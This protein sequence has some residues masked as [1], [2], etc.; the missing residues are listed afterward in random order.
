MTRSFAALLIAALT[1]AGCGSDAAEVGCAPLPE[2]AAASAEGEPDALLWTG[3]EDLPAIAGVDQADLRQAR[4]IVANVSSQDGLLLHL[5]N[6]ARIADWEVFASDAMAF[7]TGR[8]D[9]ELATWTEGAPAEPVESVCVVP[10]P[11]DWLVEADV[12]FADDA[13]SGAYFWRLIVSH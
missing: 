3:D 10:Q 8:D 12:T 7:R 11:G 2:Q 1:L 9:G 5:T 4:F 13:G 6:G